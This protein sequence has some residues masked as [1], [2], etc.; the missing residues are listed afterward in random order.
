MKTSIA[1]D[2]QYLKEADMTLR[3]RHKMNTLQVCLEEPSESLIQNLCRASND[4]ATQFAI[5]AAIGR[6]VQEKV[7]TEAEFIVWQNQAHALKKE[8]ME[9]DADLERE[10]DRYRERASEL[11]ALSKGAA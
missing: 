2:L 8:D 3:E 9:V 6:E 4:D 7:K 11:A 5:W 1:L 10:N